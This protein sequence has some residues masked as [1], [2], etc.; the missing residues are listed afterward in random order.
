MAG[1]VGRPPKPSKVH[2][3]HGNPSKKSAVL[4]GEDFSPEVALAKCPAHLRGEARKEYMRLGQELERYG[5]MSKLDRGV[6][7]GLAVAWARHVW[8]EEKIRALNAADQVNGSAG[9]VA[10]TATGYEHQSVYLQISSKEM[11]RYVKLAHEFGL[12]PAA[13]TRVHPG[14]TAQLTLPG[15]PEAS[16]DTPQ[17]PTLR[18]FA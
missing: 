4:L 2:Q 14:D 11:D 1:H 17:A 15:V 13:R 6:L 10:R 12:T 5:L 18:S 3:L 16:N 9:M 7:C 8:A